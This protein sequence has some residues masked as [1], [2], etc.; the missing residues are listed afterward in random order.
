MKTPLPGKLQKEPKKKVQHLLTN[1]PVALRK[2]DIFRLGE[3]TGA[4]VISA[5][6]TQV[7]D[8]ENLFQEASKYLVEKLTLY[9]IQWVCRPMYEKGF[10]IP[11]WIIT[12]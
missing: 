3:K 9:F 12:I 5:D 7:D 8:L 4:E 2:G 6:I 1:A 10:I 11:S